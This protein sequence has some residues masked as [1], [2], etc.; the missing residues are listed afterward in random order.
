MAPVSMLTATVLVS[1]LSV[2]KTGL[3]RL[4]DGS[5]VKTLDSVLILLH[6]DLWSA[7]EIG[8]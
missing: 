6:L 8:F 4:E 2:L 7:S 5:L 1:L 3:V